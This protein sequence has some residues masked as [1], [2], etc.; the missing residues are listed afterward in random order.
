MMNLSKGYKN[1]VY[2][3]LQVFY[4]AFN[5]LKS[6]FRQKCLIPLGKHFTS[7]QNVYTVIV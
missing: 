5:L 4:L 3:Q 1:N 6:Y 7:K 2:L